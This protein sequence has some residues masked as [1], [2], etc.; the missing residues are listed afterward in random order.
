M[1]NVLAFYLSASKTIKIKLRLSM[2]ETF[3]VNYR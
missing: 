2:V 1:F 3:M